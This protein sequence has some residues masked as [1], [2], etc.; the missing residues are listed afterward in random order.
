MNSFKLEI[1]KFT[2]FVPKFNPGI[3]QDAYKHVQPRLLH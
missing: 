3:K 1:P 2:L